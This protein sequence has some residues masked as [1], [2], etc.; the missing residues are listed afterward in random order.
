GAMF[1]VVP[2]LLWE[3]RMPPDDKNRIK[4][5]LWCLLIKTGNLPDGQA[6]KN[7]L[8]NTGIGNRCSQRYQDIFKIQHPPSLLSGL[9]EHN[10]KPTDIDIVILTHLHFDHSGG[11]TFFQNN[12]LTPTFPKARYIVQKAEWEKAVNPNERTRA[13]YIKDNLIPIKEAGQLELLDGNGEIL[14]GISVRVTG[15]HTR[16]HQIVLIESG[17]KKA[18]Y[19][20]DLI[21]T[22]AHIDLPYIMGYDLYPEETLEE[23]RRLVEQAIKEEWICFWEHDPVINCGYIRKDADGKLTVEPLV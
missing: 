4:M 1:G 20:S 22:T 3:K 19:W 8:I 12:M 18:V 11:N 21:P 2:R 15:G 13:S 9:A 10:I 14:P 23:K 5:G 16:G 17:N 7:I 6:G